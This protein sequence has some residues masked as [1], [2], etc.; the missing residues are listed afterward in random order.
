M[1]DPG[2][3]ILPL[4]LALP[5]LGAIFVMCTPK[6]ETSLH[7]GLGIAFTT[8]TFLVSLAML[9]YFDS[10]KAGFQ[11]EFDVEWIPGLGAHFKTG[12]DGISIFLVLLTT[13]MMPLTLLGT[14]T[15]VERHARE[16]VAAML[17]LETG[18]IGA[19]VALDLF[20]FYT[21]VGGDA[22]PDVLADRHL[23][24]PAPALRVDQVRRL[25][26]GR[27]AR[28]AGRDLLPLRE[29]G[30]RARRANHRPREAVDGRAAVHR[31]GVVLRRVRARVRDQG[32]AV[33]TAHV[34]ARCPRRGADSRLG[35]P[36]RRAAQVRHLR[37]H[38]VT[39]CRCSRMAP[40]CGRPALRCC[41]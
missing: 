12:V 1:T 22:D 30:A 15:S 10:T 9:R 8:I 33:P 5:L 7:R 4:L 14:R 27:L 32:A 41:R 21:F 37:F 38:C 19:F 13:L 20:L 36:G 11:L 6:S 24:R 18:M 26:D 31:A 40:R 2:A 28:D 34:V 25:H 17:V 35:D 16:F 29:G 23:G 3:F 39:R